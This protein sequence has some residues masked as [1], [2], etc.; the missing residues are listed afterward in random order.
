MRILTNDDMKSLK[1]RGYFKKEI[2][3]LDNKYDT[4]RKLDEYNISS[5]P[6]L[7]LFNSLDNGGINN[8]M[9]Y[10]CLK[11]YDLY[12]SL[13]DVSIDFKDKTSEEICVFF[14]NTKHQHRIYFFIEIIHQY[15]FP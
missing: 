2:D 13:K 3:N 5:I 6:Y 4:L 10:I 12:E 15:F 9:R 11:W 14:L 8:L 1:L 7:L